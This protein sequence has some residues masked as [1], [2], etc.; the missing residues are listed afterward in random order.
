[1]AD[2][3]FGRG[4]S[5]AWLRKRLAEAEHLPVSFREPWEA[6]T[7]ERG[8]SHVASRAVIARDRPGPPTDGGAFPRAARRV[9]A[10]AFS[11]PRVV[12][13]HFDPERPLESRPILLEL[14][15][16]GLHYLCPVRVVAVE[17]GGAPGETRF[18]F[19]IVTLEGHIERGR[20][21]FT[22]T[23]DH[24]TGEVRFHIEAR[25]QEGD[26]PNAWSA[27]GFALVGRR[28]QRAWHRL[29]HL[30]LRRMLHQERPG[31]ATLLREPVQF[32]AQRGRRIPSVEVEQED[33]QMGTTHRLSALGLSTLS[34]FR[35]L[36]PLAVLATVAQER[37]APGALR[38]LTQGKIPRALDALAL[39]E[40]AADKTAWI[41]PRTD[42]P[43]MFGRALT[44]S[45]LGAWLRPAGRRRWAGAALLGAGA[46]VVGT[47]LSYGL[48]E[49]VR[50]ATGVPSA[51]LGVIED[52]LVAGASAG[53]ARRL[54]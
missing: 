40:M 30:R 15:A 46:A 11:D 29:A 34:G 9:Q 53:L 17:R 41:P 52:V 45:L 27:L 23:K 37:R 24:A 22:L 8:F 44:G 54:T 43:A 21:H 42:P 31:D 48:R 39:G 13:P 3:R 36:A 1:M 16:M 6:M 47:Y 32:T 2:W 33:E 51:V 5:H 50:L 12:V 14:R 10:L 20:E 28:Y 26:F 4:W 49:R 38:R 19:G 25:W 35:S 18:G 7:L